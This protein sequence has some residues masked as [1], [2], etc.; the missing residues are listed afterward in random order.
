MLKKHRTL[1]LSSC[2]VLVLI[3]ISFSVYKATVPIGKKSIANIKT[4]A[5]LAEHSKIFKKGVEMIR[6]T[7]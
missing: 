6:V 3:A 5:D 7:S 4:P 2:I 1:L